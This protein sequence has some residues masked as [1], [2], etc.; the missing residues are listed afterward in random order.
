MTLSTNALGVGLDGALQAPAAAPFGTPEH[1]AGVWTGPAGPQSGVRPVSG[2][3]VRWS[4][5][6]HR[7]RRRRASSRGGSVGLRPA[8]ASRPTCRPAIMVV[9]PFFGYRFG[10]AG[11]LRKRGSQRRS[12]AASGRRLEGGIVHFFGAADPQT[13]SR[14]CHTRPSLRLRQGGWRSLPR[15]RGG[16]VRV[17]HCREMV[18]RERGPARC[19]S[20]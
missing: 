11:G 16:A 2:G 6:G 15:P 18:N 17:G 5:R 12:D 14:A 3:P 4:C 9:F 10:V 7:C 13:V 1:G 19:G 8:W 20:G